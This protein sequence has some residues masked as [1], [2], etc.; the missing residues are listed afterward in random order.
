MDVF[1]ILGG[2][3]RI[4]CGEVVYISLDGKRG[5]R[6]DGSVVHFSAKQI[7]HAREVAECYPSRYHALAE[8]L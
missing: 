5:M 7:E 3:K 1:A 4:D 6:E 2:Y 8:Y